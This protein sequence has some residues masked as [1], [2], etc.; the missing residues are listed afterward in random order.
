[1]ATK[2]SELTLNRV[3]L[4]VSPANKGARILLWKHDHGET[5]MEHAEVCKAAAIANPAAA[6]VAFNRSEL[7]GAI[8]LIGREI[9]KGDPKMTI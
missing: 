1:V 4:V 5:E 6:A 8:D 2:L 9:R 3:A 7:Y